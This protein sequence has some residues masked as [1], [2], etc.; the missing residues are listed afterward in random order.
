M[1]TPAPS[2]FQSWEFSEQELSSATILND[3]QKKRIQ[4]IQCGIAE[5][6][7]NVEASTKEQVVEAEIQRAFLKG[8]V[9]I[10]G[11]LL[12]TSAAMELQ[13]ND[14]DYETTQIAVSQ[15][16]PDGPNLYTHFRSQE[17]DANTSNQSKE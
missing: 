3:F 15:Q 7:L 11:H 12:E 1:P 8:Q 6:L 9:Q 10:L 4:T 16:F 17:S 5:Q 14:S 13:I 2:R